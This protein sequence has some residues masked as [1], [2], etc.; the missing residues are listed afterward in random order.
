MSALCNTMK[1][2][3][4]FAE[5]KDPSNTLRSKTK[6]LKSQNLSS[7]YYKGI[8]RSSDVFRK[9]ENPANHRSHKSP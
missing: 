7:T 2:G 1:T 6:V 9:L 8:P 3:E 4:T 5:P